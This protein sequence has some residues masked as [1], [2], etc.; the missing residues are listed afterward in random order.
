M[1][2]HSSMFDDVGNGTID[3]WMVQGKNY[4]KQHFVLYES[5]WTSREAKAVF[6][7]SHIFHL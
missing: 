2:Y 6:L 3:V 7:L 1:E 4:V 5:T